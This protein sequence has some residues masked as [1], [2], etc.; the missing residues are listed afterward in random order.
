VQDL[1]SQVPV[2]WPSFG[3][4][5]AAGNTVTAKTVWSGLPGTESEATADV[6][7]Y[8]MPDL[9]SGDTWTASNVQHA[10]SDYRPADDAFS[11]DSTADSFGGQ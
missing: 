5:E 11:A 2:G 3:G 8:T 1:S 6:S 7:A 4:S 10:D 9:T